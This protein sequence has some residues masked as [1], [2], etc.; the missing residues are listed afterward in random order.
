MT[1]KQMLAVYEAREKLTGEPRIITCPECGI[2]TPLRAG[3]LA[4]FLEEDAEILLRGVFIV[5]PCGHTVDNL[6]FTKD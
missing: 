1:P 3:R 5:G 6:T 4:M 2:K